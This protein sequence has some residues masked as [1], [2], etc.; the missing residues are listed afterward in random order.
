VSEEEK[1]RVVIATALATILAS[2][3][4]LLLQP[5]FSAIKW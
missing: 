4:D 2:M 3:L 1:Q 5:A